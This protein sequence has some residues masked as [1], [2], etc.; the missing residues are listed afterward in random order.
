M[1]HGNFKAEVRQGAEITTHT[2]AGIEERVASNIITISGLEDNGREDTVPLSIPGASEEHVAALIR[3]VGLEN[4]RKP[5]VQK[6]FFNWINGHVVDNNVRICPYIYNKKLGWYLTVKGKPGYKPPAYADPNNLAKIPLKL[7]SIRE[8]NV[9]LKPLI[10][11][12]IQESIGIIFKK[13]GMAGQESEVLR[14]FANGLEE[15]ATIGPD[16][17]N[18]NL[19]SNLLILQD[20]FFKEQTKQLLDIQKGVSFK[21]LCETIRLTSKHYRKGEITK[22]ETSLIAY[23]KEH[24]TPEPLDPFRDI[25]DD[26]NACQITS[27]IVYEYLKTVSA[28]NR[29]HRVNAAS[30]LWNEA[31][32]L[33]QY[34]NSKESLL[35]E[36]PWTYQRKVICHQPKASKKKRKKCRTCVLS[37]E[38]A[39][40]VLMY[41]YHQGSPAFLPTLAEFTLGA[42]PGEGSCGMSEEHREED[43]I[44][45]IKISDFRFGKRGL[46]KMGRVIIC[47]QKTIDSGMQ[48]R[49]VDLTPSAHSFWFP[50]VRCFK[51][52]RLNDA[53]INTYSHGYVAKLRLECYRRLGITKYFA[54]K[55]GVKEERIGKD[56]KA[57]ADLGRHSYLTNLFYHCVQTLNKQKSWVRE[58]AG[59]EEGTKTIEKHYLGMTTP[60][61]AKK[62]IYMKAPKDLTW[63]P[64]LTK[65]KKRAATNVKN[66]LAKSK[67]NLSEEQKAKNLEARRAGRRRYDSDPERAAERAHANEKRRESAKAYWKS[68]SRAERNSGTAKM[69]KAKADCWAKLTP[70]EK[71]AQTRYAADQRIEVSRRKREELRTP[72]A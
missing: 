18:S 12:P 66:A 64:H 36:N 45:P 60:E 53:P 4:A 21:T 24:V 71:A 54:D 41:L 23:V 7:Q 72:S 38:Q 59:H 6:Q 65:W 58:Q 22:L 56:I 70:E 17:A 30:G 68:K 62:Y 51:R 14:I 37:P 31:A 61:K 47:C 44:E 40:K 8:D 1:S 57:T 2:Q 15:L 16:F 42:R 27:D 63:D 49:P 33:P 52:L 50:I 5:T 46:F 13:H 55:L 69:R 26:I 10:S 28:G 35:K 11:D 19:K 43:D 20:K 29:R 67:E 9:S 48:F 25:K 39:M 3:T 34:Q 32:L